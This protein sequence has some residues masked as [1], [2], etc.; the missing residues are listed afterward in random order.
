MKNC[1]LLLIR[2]DQEDQKSL[3]GEKL[4]KHHHHRVS[5]EDLELLT[6]AQDVISLDIMLKDAK[7]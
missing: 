1:C 4:M 3:E 7:A 6:S 2:R 5:I